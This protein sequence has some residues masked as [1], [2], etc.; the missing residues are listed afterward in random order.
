[1][2]VDYDEKARVFGVNLEGAFKEVGSNVTID[3]AKVH[4]AV[5]AAYKQDL[6]VFDARVRIL[7]DIVAI[8]KSGDSPPEEKYRK[9]DNLLK[10]KGELPNQ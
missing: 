1:M 4:E 9:I 5:V 8:A 3:M 7:D 6:Q 10:A 2:S